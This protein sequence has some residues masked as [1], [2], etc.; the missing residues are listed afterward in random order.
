M[1][2]NKKFKKMEYN[3]KLFKVKMIDSM[4]CLIE[5]KN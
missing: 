5:V 1:K 2:Y 3:K 4:K